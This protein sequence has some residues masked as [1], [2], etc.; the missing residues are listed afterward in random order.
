MKKEKTKKR[1]FLNKNK[2]KKMRI[3]TGVSSVFFLTERLVEESRPEP[4]GN[5]TRSSTGAGRP[6]Q[7]PSLTSELNM[8]SDNITKN[9]L[10]SAILGIM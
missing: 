4:T 6:D 7:F 9:I 1:E 3:L 10:G 8:Y 5:P 2:N